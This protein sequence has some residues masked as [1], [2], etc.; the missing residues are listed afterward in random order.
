[1]SLHGVPKVVLLSWTLVAANAVCLLAALA[2]S[3]FDPYG[4]LR[5]YP[6]VISPI[7]S[8][9]WAVVAFGSLVQLGW[10]WGWQ[11]VA[12]APVALWPI[13]GGLF[14]LWDCGVVGCS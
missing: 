7:V 11:A 4:G 1:M 6:I 14:V 8:L 13:W 3:Y 9:S 10:R 2:L 12:A 5:A